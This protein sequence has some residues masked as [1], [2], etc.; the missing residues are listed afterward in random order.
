MKYWEKAVDLKEKPGQSPRS[1]SK[2][3]PSKSGAKSKQSPSPSSRKPPGTK[4]KQSPSP[5]SRKPS[6]PE[7]EKNMRPHQGGSSTAS[8][9][10]KEI[11]LL[12]ER[13]RGAAKKEDYLTAREL[14]VQAHML[15]EK[16]IAR[17]E[18]V[19]ER[20]VNSEDYAL[21]KSS[22]LEQQR[23]KS[24]VDQQAARDEIALKQSESTSTSKV[25]RV[26]SR[27]RLELEEDPVFEA[28]VDEHDETSQGE[29]EAH[30]DGDTDDAV[31]GGSEL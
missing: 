25:D 5:G 30:G 6:A 8:V 22:K 26:G 20:A 13:M 4:S 10:V 12:E 15:R 7:R 3:A 24:E 1:G 11:R 17:L 21:A 19:K 28:V 18:Y 16:E 9:F 23:L 2:K 14:Q 27:A 29:N 31:E